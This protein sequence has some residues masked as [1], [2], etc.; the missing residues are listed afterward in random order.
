MSH[1]LSLGL[2]TVKIITPQVKWTLY[3]VGSYKVMRQQDGLLLV[4]LK[5]RCE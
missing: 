4:E 3:I 5:M 1:R 2:V